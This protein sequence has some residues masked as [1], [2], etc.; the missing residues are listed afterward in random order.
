M[1]VLKLC[2]KIVKILKK[3]I[4]LILFENDIFVLHQKNGFELCLKRFNTSKSDLI[5]LLMKNQKPLTKKQLHSYQIVST[6]SKH[7]LG[8][9]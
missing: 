2:L 9:S 1:C 6:N 4:I 7:M 8:D 3:S 5:K